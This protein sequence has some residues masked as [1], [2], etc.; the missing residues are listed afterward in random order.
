M[1]FFNW[2][3]LI[4]SSNF[5]LYYLTS[6]P[7]SQLCRDGGVEGL[8]RLGNDIFFLSSW[9]LKIDFFL[10]PLSCCEYHNTIY[11]YLYMIYNIH[12]FLFIT[13]ALW[14]LE[15]QV[16][17]KKLRK[18]VNNRDDQVVI[19]LKSKI[20]DLCDRQFCWWRIPLTYNHQL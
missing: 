13:Q 11:M 5:E 16:N 17:E 19:S 18:L 9:I 20:W 8:R 7:K 10:K 4:W 14:R 15:K 6:A 3:Q 2:I 1:A 12:I